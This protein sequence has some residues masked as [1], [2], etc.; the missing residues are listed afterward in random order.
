MPVN[1]PDSIINKYPPHLR[2]YAR[3]AIQRGYQFPDW[4]MIAL[5]GQGGGQCCGGGSQDNG[6]VKLTMT[7]GTPIGG[8]KAVYIK[9]DQK[10]YLYDID[11]PT[12]Y[13]RYIGVSETA[14]TANSQ[15][16]IVVNGPLTNIGAGFITGTPY[17]IGTGG[18]LTSTPPLTGAIKQVGV[19]IDIDKLNITPTI[20]IIQT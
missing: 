17:Y 14:A 5:I 2:E 15:I 12:C 7:A 9:P 16:V 11:D 13:E 19:G 20:H 10:V 3:R 1:V 8:G 18:S 4:D 6:A